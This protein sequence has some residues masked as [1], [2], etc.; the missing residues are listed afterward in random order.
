MP[1]IRVI[2]ST[3]RGRI[4]TFQN[5]SNRISSRLEWNDHIQ[6]FNS[7]YRRAQVWLDNAVLRNSTPYVPMR[8]GVLYKSGQLGT[9]PGEGVV[10]WIAPY[11]RY[12]YYGK[13]MAGP[14]YG[15]KYATDKDLHISQAVH[16]DAQSFWF[17]AAKA[18]NKPLWIN[19]VRRIAGGG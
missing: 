17:E 4:I 19:G 6:R 15:P 12:L 3:P 5:G 10:Q 7:Q 2:V 14:K 16:P 11:A 9:T 1:V 13:V 8:T 18:Q